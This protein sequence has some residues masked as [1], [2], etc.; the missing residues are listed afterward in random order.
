MK[1]LKL[2]IAFA[3]MLCVSVSCKNDSEVN[4]SIEPARG[5]NVTVYVD[6][7]TGVNYLQ[8]TFGMYAGFVT[9][10]YN[11]DGSLMVTK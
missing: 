9:P 3:I 8:F 6:P 5:H 10:R 11:A 4:S 7:E 2:F 1:N